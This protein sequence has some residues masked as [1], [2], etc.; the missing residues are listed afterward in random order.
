MQEGKIMNNG[1]IGAVRSLTFWN[2]LLTRGLNTFLQVALA[3]VGVG[4]AGVVDLDYMG[5]LNLAAGGALV[6]VL[7]SFVRATTPKS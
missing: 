7:T 6:S 5:I 4:A 2:D 1:I 3:A